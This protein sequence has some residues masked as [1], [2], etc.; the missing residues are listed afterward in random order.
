MRHPRRAHGV[1]GRPGGAGLGRRLS[2]ATV[3]E[4]LASAE[5]RFGDAPAIVT[6]DGSESFRELARSTRAAAE[7]LRRR[8]LKP[9]DRVLIAARNSP[10]LVGFRRR[11]TP[12]SPG[13]RSTTCGAISSQLSRSST[14]NWMRWMRGSMSPRRRPSPRNHWRRRPSSTPPERPAV[15][16]V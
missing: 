16:R 8:G 1:Q 3:P 9:G 10:S 7:G 2:F 4:L 5:Q 6:V 14:G 13:P 15:P 12:S 11:S